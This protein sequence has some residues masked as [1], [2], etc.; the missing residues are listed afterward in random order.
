MK[1]PPFD[2]VRARRLGDV[3]DLLAHS[4]R[5]VKILAGGQS[6]MPV[7]NMRM[8]HPDVLVDITGIEDAGELQIDR[9]GNLHIPLTARQADVATDYR[10]RERWPLLS[11]A[12]S[13]IGHPQIRNSGTVCGSLAHADSAA[14]LPAVMT[15]L[16]ATLH[17]V[18]SRGER[19]IPAGEFMLGTF[20]TLL[21]PDEV[22][23]EIVVKPVPAGTVWGFAE[24][25][26]RRGDFAT[27][28]AAAITTR[29]G[30]RAHGTT[31]VLFGLEGAPT[32]AHAVGAH[33]DGRP[34]DTDVIGEAAIHAADDAEPVDDIHASAQFRTELAHHLTR[35]VLESALEAT[36]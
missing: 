32:I 2:Y 3:I 5:E 27:V 35:T 13:H 29:S 25:A 1:P 9:A 34:I 4:R 15:A 20:M 12:I 24:F 16:G 21:E 18:S 6:L 19:Q 11:A 22:L 10:V 8:S 28:G 31:V 30:S 14:E 33:L 36:P 7:L 23:R 26:P 17:A